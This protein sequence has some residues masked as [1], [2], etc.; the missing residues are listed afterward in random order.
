MSEDWDKVADEF[1]ES[2][3]KYKIA[4]RGLLDW[5]QKKEN[6]QIALRARMGTSKSYLMSVSL[7]W[8]A[9]HVRFARQLPVFNKHRQRGSDKIIINDTTIAYLQQREPDYSRTQRT[10]QTS[11]LESVNKVNPEVGM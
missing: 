4:L 7:G 10:C 2:E 5:Q 9:E 1:L 6:H 11:E 3:P 8:V